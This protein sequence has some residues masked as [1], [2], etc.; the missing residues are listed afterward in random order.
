MEKNISSD[1]STELMKRAKA[2]DLMQVL[3]LYVRKGYFDNQRIE[4]GVTEMQNF[5]HPQIIEITDSEAK[6][7]QF[8]DEQKELLHDCNTLIVKNEVLIS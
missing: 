1:F 2:F 5:K 6:I 8:I 7:N 4:W 3:H